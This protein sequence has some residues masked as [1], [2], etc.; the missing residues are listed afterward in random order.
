M[1]VGNN[2]LQVMRGISSI[3]LI[4]FEWRSQDF[5]SKVMYIIFYNIPSRFYSEWKTGCFQIDFYMPE[6]Y[7]SW[8]TYK[9]TAWVMKTACR[10]SIFLPE[11]LTFL[12]S[13]TSVESDI[14]R[15]KEESRGIWES[16]WGYFQG[17]RHS[18]SVTTVFTAMTTVFVA[19]RCR[20]HLIWKRS[21]WQWRRSSGEKTAHLTGKSLPKTLFGIRKNCLR[22]RSRRELRPFSRCFLQ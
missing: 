17:F 20:V 9:Q 13:L 16:I 15:N 7:F 22:I 12:Q 8:H 1:F 10:L 19:V 4:F 3:I 5:M 11:F 18:V 2:D 21:S 14:R 6:R